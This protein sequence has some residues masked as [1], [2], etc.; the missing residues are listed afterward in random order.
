MVDRSLAYVT[1]TSRTTKVH[2]FEYKIYRFPMYTL[3]KKYIV[4]KTTA[5]S[6]TNALFCTATPTE[7]ADWIRGQIRHFE[8]KTRHF[9][10]KIHHF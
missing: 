1:T 9:E 4:N 7:F 2:H 10:C 6:L 3:P 8:Y 5:P